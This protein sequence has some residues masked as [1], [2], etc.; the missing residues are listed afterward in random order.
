VAAALLAMQVA[1]FA[2]GARAASELPYLFQQLDHAAYRNSFNA[3]FHGEPD[4]APWLR[5]YLNKRDGVDTPGQIVTAAG[6]N[7]ELYE[8]CQ[9]HNCPGNYIYVLFSRGGHKAWAL[10]TREGGDYRFFGKPNA[11]QQALLTAV[12]RR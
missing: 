10:F 12:A 1:V 8:V 6:E 4:L 11:Q 7:Y 2:I 9:P 5:R 3:L